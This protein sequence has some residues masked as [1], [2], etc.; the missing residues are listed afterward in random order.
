MFRHDPRLEYR[1]LSEQDRIRAQELRKQLAYVLDRSRF[2]RARLGVKRPPAT[3]ADALALLR[4]SPPT[5]RRDLEEHNDEFHCA[6]LDD[7]REVV[8]TSGTSG[9]PI[10]LTLTAG[11]IEKLEVTERMAFEAAEL[12]PGDT[13]LMCV[14]L[15]AMF[16]AGLAYY[17]GLQRAGCRVLRQGAASP[18]AQVRLMRRFAVTGVM[19]VP[20]FLL[21]LLREMRRAGIGPDEVPLRKA[22]LVGD[23]IRTRELEPNQTARAIRELW[24]IE[25]YGSYGNTEMCGS[26]CECSAF[27]G[28]HIHP[29]LVFAEILREDGQP[30]AP[31][32]EGALVVTTLRSEGTPLIRYRTGDIAFIVEDPCPCGR[33]SRRIGPI[34][35]RED[36]MLK[37]RGT[38]VYPAAVRDLVGGAAF[39][40]QC[41]LVADTDEHGSDRLSVLVAVDPGAE[42]RL[43][44]LVERLQDALRVRPEVTIAPP[45]QI[46]E[47]MSPPHY[48]KKRWFIDRRTRGVGEA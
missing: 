36:Q 25:L 5:T 46:E 45:A 3:D 16:M 38:K 18:A 47:L 24:D 31:G 21:A 1:P 7:Q 44:E 32:E 15:N 48:R 33:F 28:N 30:A 41:A 27:R 4:D 20:S 2:Y 19:T 17:R 35:A 42:G 12:G 11:D 14:T 43:K 8:C 10:A 26:M 40:R 6:P 22:V 13:V 9:R 39:V 23:A 37:I 34:L 29:D